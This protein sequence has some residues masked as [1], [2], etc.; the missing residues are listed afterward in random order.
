M[1]WLDDLAQK[2]SGR[3]NYSQREID[4]ADLTF[5]LLAVR[6]RQDFVNEILEAVFGKPESATEKRA[7]TPE[8]FDLLFKPTKKPERKR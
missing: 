8:V 2:A 1:A 3:L 6:G 7:L 4:E 5:L